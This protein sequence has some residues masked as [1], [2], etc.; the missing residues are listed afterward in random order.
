MTSPAKAQIVPMRL[1]SIALRSILTGDGAAA[2][3]RCGMVHDDK[4]GRL[5]SIDYVA[6][7][8][9]V[10]EPYTEEAEA[11]QEGRANPNDSLP[12]YM[13]FELL[14]AMWDLP[15]VIRGS[16]LS[17]EKHFLPDN[18]GLQLEIRGGVC[19]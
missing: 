13:I 4:S 1:V 8:S 12:T 19:T 5:A 16:L 10:V 14:L 6:D 7:A 15:I 2:L 11:V 17:D 3:R 18:L 9:I